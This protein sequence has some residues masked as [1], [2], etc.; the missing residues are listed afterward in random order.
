[1]PHMYTHPTLLFLEIGRSILFTP[2]VHLECSCY[3]EVIH[4]S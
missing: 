2:V 3:L 4:G 1:M